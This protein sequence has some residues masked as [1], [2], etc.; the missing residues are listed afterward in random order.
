MLL[1]I[2]WLL[3]CV[4]N[5]CSW[6]HRCSYICSKIFWKTSLLIYSKSPLVFY[7]WSHRLKIIKLDKIHMILQIHSEIQLCVFLSNCSY[8]H[9]HCLQN[10][11]IFCDYISF[12]L[13]ES[14]FYWWIFSDNIT[15]S[16]FFLICYQ[17]QNFS[18]SFYLSGKIDIM[19]KCSVFEYLSAFFICL[20]KFDCLYDL[21]IHECD[22]TL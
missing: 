16:S 7:S 22:L 20:L 5:I 17:V 12:V 14:C 4:F 1:N 3:E 13:D 6:I 18:H 2:L 8:F 10:V 11:A 9:S 19:Q 15:V 21:L